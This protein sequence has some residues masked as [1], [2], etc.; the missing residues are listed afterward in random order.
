MPLRCRRRRPAH[1]RRPAIIRLA[2][3]Q[4]RPP[5]VP[6]PRLP[7]A[8]LPIAAAR[9]TRIRRSRLVRMRVIQLRLPVRVRMLRVRR[10]N[11]KLLR[12]ANMLRANRVPRP[13]R[14]P[15][16]RVPPSRPTAL[17]P[18]PKAN[19]PRP[20]R[21]PRKRV[22]PSQPTALHPSP[23]AS[24]PRLGRALQKRVRPSQAIALRRRSHKS[25][26]PRP[27]PQASPKDAESVSSPVHLASADSCTGYFS[28]RARRSYGFCRR[29]GSRCR[30]PNRAH[31]VPASVNQREIIGSS[32]TGPVAQLDRAAVS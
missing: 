17:H 19:L 27:S 15:R 18:S 28:V 23:R 8:T 6:P 1:P 20:G 12:P 3:R 9:R 24:R 16:K 11:R 31:R 29:R 7:K 25:Q 21:A 30:I 4:R 14:A 5:A 13:R 32:C 2:Q 22:P 26:A 10:V